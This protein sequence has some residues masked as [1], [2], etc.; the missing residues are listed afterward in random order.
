LDALGVIKCNAY[1][2]YC[3]IFIFSYAEQYI[4]QCNQRIISSYREVTTSK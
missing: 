4:G 1:I 2:L 3:I